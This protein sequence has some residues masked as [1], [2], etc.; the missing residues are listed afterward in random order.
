MLYTFLKLKEL[1]KYIYI[2]L[3]NDLVETLTLNIFLIE[4]ALHGK[5]TKI[6]YTAYR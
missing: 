6:V 5:V 4:I 2:S 1:K 3:G